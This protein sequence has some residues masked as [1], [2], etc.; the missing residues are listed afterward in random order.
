MGAPIQHLRNGPMGLRSHPTGKG[1]PRS[2]ALGAGAGSQLPAHPQPRDKCSRSRSSGWEGGGGRGCG[3][4]PH[5]TPT[6][7]PHLLAL[8]D[9]GLPPG[10]RSLLRVRRVTLPARVDRRF[11]QP[12]KSGNTHVFLIILVLTKVMSRT[13]QSCEIKKVLVPRV[14]QLRRRAF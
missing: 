6:P 4:L 3:C 5:N 11:M 9:K 13:H 14:L 2:Q 12:A 7:Q 10:K 8:P 1:H